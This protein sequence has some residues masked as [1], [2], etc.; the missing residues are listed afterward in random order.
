MVKE[1]L[2]ACQKVIA[3]VTLPGVCI[4]WV[5][6]GYCRMKFHKF[7]AKSR[8]STK[9]HK[10]CAMK[11]KFSTFSIHIFTV[12]KI[13]TFCDPIKLSWFWWMKTTILSLDGTKEKVKFAHLLLPFYSL[14]QTQ[15]TSKNHIWSID[16]WPKKLWIMN[17]NVMQIK[18]QYKKRQ[19]SPLDQIRSTKMM[20][21]VTLCLALVA[22]VYGKFF[23][24]KI[25][26]L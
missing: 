6:L 4:R 20:Y 23:I 13:R 21:T 1:C 14:R 25:Q 22:V 15:P 24:Y 12:N 16:R 17:K 5:C 26:R 18:N 9:S 10:R 19:F 3:M 7:L 2:S 11:M 8:H